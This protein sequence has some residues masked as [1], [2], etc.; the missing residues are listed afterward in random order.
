[1]RVPCQ[2]SVDRKDVQKVGSKILVKKDTPA[3]FM[4]QDLLRLLCDGLSDYI[5]YDFRDSLEYRGI[6]VCAAT[7]Y[8]ATG[9]KS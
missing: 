2:I 3:K 8:V 5:E 7:L 4:K 1:M 6:M 9:D